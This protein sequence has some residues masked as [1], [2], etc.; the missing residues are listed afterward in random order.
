LF[1]GVAQSE[2]ILTKRT[3]CVGHCINRNLHEHFVVDLE[4]CLHVL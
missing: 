3:N 4:M 2:P 1:V